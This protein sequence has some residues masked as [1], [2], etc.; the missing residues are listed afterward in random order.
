MSF[1]IRAAN[2]SDLPVVCD[3]HAKCFPE[4]F[5]TRLGKKL[6]TAY[7]YEFYLE[8]PHLFL[9]CE[10]D[11]GKMCG[12]IMGYVLGK[13]N[14][15]SN[16]MKKNRL[17]MGMKV[18]GLLL[19]FDKLAWRKVKKAFSRKKTPE[20]TQ[21]QG[22]VIDKTGEGDLLSICVTEEMRGTGAAVAMVNKY[23]EVLSAHGHKVCYLTC[24]TSNPRGL[25][26][27]KKL[28]YDVTEETKEKIC[29]RK[30]LV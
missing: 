23:N 17:R 10:N 22:A 29:F 18:I 8:A 6:L 4:S 11:E 5:S 24:E 28:G 16:F 27:Y 26:F 13:T 1:T 12:F 3:V 25:A 21:Q 7:Y 30:D 20:Q 2:E 14:A 19:C 15:I 9:V